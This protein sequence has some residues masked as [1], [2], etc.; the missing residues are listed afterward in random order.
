MSSLLAIKLVVFELLSSTLVVSI[1]AVFVAIAVVGFVV[2]EVE[3]FLL[4]DV[5]LLADE[6]ALDLAVFGFPSLPLM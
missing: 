2:L 6:L 1:L 3:I 5:V 4:S